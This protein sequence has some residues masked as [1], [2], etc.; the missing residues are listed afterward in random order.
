[1][2]K[3][4]LKCNFLVFSVCLFVNILI[5]FGVPID[6]Q[7]LLYYS[8]SGIV[9]QSFGV[10]YL[11][12]V[13]SKRLQ[14]RI[15]TKALCLKEWKVYLL[16]IIRFGVPA[17][18]EGIIYLLVQ[19]VNAAFAGS[20]GTEAL[21]VKAYV[22][23]FSGYM[24]IGTSAVNTAVFVLIGQFYGREDKDGIRV[25]FRAGL[26]VGILAT[27]CISVLLLLFSKDI[28]LLFTKEEEII[29]WVQELL[30]IQT[31]LEIIRV[32]TALAVSALKAVGEIRVPFGMMIIGGTCN[33]L[34]SY[35]FGIV[36]EWGLAGIWIGFFVDL[37]IRGVVECGYFNRY[38]TKNKQMI[39]SL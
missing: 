21:L 25:I 6:K 37:V 2:M 24:V 29:K 34:V 18:M 14:I 11:H 31:F 7:R 10:Y 8:L 33:I 1:M 20:L 4:V 5:H 35:Y 39:N 9:G 17:G 36:L 22:S 15:R 38:L 23:T 30:F 13:V 32:L 16:K 27:L 28:L 12:Q 3:S 26:F 19:M